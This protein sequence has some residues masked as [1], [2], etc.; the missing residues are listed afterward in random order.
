[1][2]L[3][4]L[5]IVLIISAAIYEVNA[6]GGRGGGRGGSRGGGR[7]GSRGSSSG[8]RGS[9]SSSSV[10][11]GGRRGGGRR[12]SSSSSSAWSS[13]S[14]GLYRGFGAGRRTVKK[15]SKY[16]V[17]GLGA[18]N[19]NKKRKLKRKW[20]RSRKWSSFE[21][22]DEIAEVDGLLCRN[23]ADCN[24]IDPNLDCQDYELDFTPNV[25]NM[26]VNIRFEILILF[27]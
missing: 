26:T 5:A 13:A 27:M 4:Y 11:G 24:W 19:A 25:S 2:K 9:S 8:S 14:G 1:M 20:S 6:R 12:T 16:A 10:S 22:W 21:D 18:Y 23:D 17:K 7:G 15:L 3:R